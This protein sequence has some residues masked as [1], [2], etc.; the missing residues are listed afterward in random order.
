MIIVQDL[1]DHSKEFSELPRQ[2][3]FVDPPQKKD[4]PTLDIVFK[5][6]QQL[7]AMR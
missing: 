4:K 7:Q 5:L 3:L 2:I 1:G 6:E